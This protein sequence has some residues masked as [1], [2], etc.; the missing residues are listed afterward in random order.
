MPRRFV[1]LSI[2][3]ENDVI[4]DPPFMRPK[5]TYQKHQETVEEANTFFPGVGAEEFPGGEGFAAAEFVTLSTHNGTHLDAPW[6]FHPTMDG[7]KPAMTIDE[8]PLDWC[9]RPGVKLDFR[10]FEDGYVVS[11]KDVEEEL[12]RIG[13]DLQ[14][15]D[16]VLVNTRAGQAVG[17]PNFVNIGC[18]MGYEATMYLLERGVRLTG[19]DA[20]SWDAPFSYTAKKVAETLANPSRTLANPSR[21]LAN[22]SQTLATSSQTL[23]NPSQTL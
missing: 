5:I 18:G 23:V 14:P 19:T 4:T 22:P 20:W 21:T 12:D 7:G 16:I 11:A 1:D 17:D 3:L 10:K 13:Y 2:Y 6:H 15:F 9:F 8:V